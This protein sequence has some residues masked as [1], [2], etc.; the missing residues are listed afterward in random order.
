V[1]STAALA[2]GETVSTC[3]RCGAEI[4]FPSADAVWPSKWRYTF[5]LN[6]GQLNCPTKGQEVY[7]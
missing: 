3:N 1:R 2:P 5:C 7:D 4:V 6:C